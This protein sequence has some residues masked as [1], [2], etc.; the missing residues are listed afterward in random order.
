MATQ[1][2]A[3][4]KAN[5]LFKQHKFEE[6]IEA[7]TEAL[8]FGDN[9]ILFSNRA[10]AWIKL[11]MMGAAME[12]AHKAINTDPNYAK[13]YVLSASWSYSSKSILMTILF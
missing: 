9:A 4:A 2:E 8:K 11:D 13:G 1:E 5:E 10:Y 12:D 7:Y 3:K 6:A